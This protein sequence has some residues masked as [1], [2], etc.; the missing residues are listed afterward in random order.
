MS[1]PALA[2]RP[3]THRPEERHCGRAIGESQAVSYPPGSLQA[4]ILA[5]SRKAPPK[6]WAEV[7]SDLSHNHDHYLYSAPKKR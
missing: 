5:L 4:R 7:P 2:R 6:D 1:R 3:R